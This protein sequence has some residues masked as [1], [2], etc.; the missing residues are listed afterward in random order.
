MDA[1]LLNTTNTA[2]IYD[3][4]GHC[5]DAGCAVKT[6]PGNPVAAPLLATGRLVR[7]ADPTP[8]TTPKPSARGTKRAEKT[9]EEENA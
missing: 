5:V 1:R 2:L 4:A 3:I 9:Q 8:T 6:D 7:L